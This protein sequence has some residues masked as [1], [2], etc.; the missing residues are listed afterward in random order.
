MIRTQWLCW[1]CGFTTL[2]ESAFQQHVCASYICGEDFPV[3]A[4]I[5]DNDE[6]DGAFGSL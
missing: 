3:L 4:R 6:D 5:W 1:G 2:E